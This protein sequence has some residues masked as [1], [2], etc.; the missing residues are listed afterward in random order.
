M[1]DSRRG[2]ATVELALGLGVLMLLLTGLVSVAT[3]T[4]IQLGLVAAAQ[5]AAHAAA[6]APSPA[7]AERRG[8]ERGLVVGQGHPLGNGSLAVLVDARQFDHGGRVRAAA[9]YTV[10]GREVV[11]LG[12]GSLTLIRQH[13]EPVAL[14]RSLP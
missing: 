4:A 6:L 9:S 12:P 3:V 8:I 7:E 2:Q 13:V 14:H 11:L 10:T 1:H 5:E